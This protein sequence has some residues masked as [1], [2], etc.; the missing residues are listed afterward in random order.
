MAK[1]KLQPHATRQALNVMTAEPHPSM[2]APAFPL[3]IDDPKVAPEP[4]AIVRLDN[5]LVAMF[6]EDIATIREFCDPADV[7]TWDRP[8]DHSWWSEWPVAFKESPFDLARFCHAVGSIRGYAA[9][10]DVTPCEFI[11]HVTA[12]TR[13]KQ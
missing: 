9:T 7:P 5:D 13:S 6:R 12:Y 8:W 11:D 1:R 4:F 2:R 3:A 10:L